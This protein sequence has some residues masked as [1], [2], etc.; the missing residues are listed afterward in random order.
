MTLA[1]LLR[2]RSGASSAEFALVLPLLILLLFGV[3]DGGR[4]LWEVN[5]AEKAAQAGA[6]FAVVTTPVASGLVTADYL[7]VG[8]LTQGDIIPRTAFGT[9]TCGSTACC[10]TGLTCTQPYPALGTFDST[11][12]QRIVTRIR[13]MHPEVTSA[14]VRIR[15]SGSGLGYAGDPNGM[16]VSP[17]VTVQ[18]TGLQFR[19]LF[20]GMLFGIPMPVFSATLTAEDS[21]GN[22][23]N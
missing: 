17:L 3:I 23:S 14:N 13:A 4:W 5:K 22:Q 7:G 11:A 10:S 8:G 18:L 1:S 2:S 21:D 9:V 6:R 19:P 15:Y 12:F 20:S 16:D